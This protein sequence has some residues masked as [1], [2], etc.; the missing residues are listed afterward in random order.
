MLLKEMSEL[1]GTSTIK[2]KDYASKYRCALIGFYILDIVIMIVLVSLMYNQGSPFS[3]YIF[4]LV[5]VCLLFTLI[6]NLWLN[7]DKWLAYKFYRRHANDTVV[8]KTYS[9]DSSSLYNI[10]YCTGFKRVKLDKSVEFYKELFISACCED[11]KYSH[12]LMKYMKK[13]ECDYESATQVYIIQTSNKS[14]FINFKED[15][16]ED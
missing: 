14:Y 5:I 2:L 7:P 6:S 8:L 3:T 9:L 12:L 16:K 11:S 4:V 10:L 1:W 15:N 13:Y